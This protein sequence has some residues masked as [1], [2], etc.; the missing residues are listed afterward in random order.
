MR[1]EDAFP[2]L[3]RHML[4]EAIWWR[5]YKHWGQGYLAGEGLTELHGDRSGGLKIINGMRYTNAPCVVQARVYE[6][7]R[8]WLSAV[9]SYPNGI[10]A[11]DRYFWELYSADLLPDPE[12]F[13]TEEEMEQRVRELL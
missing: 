5:F 9:Y 3:N 11:E 10:G 12:H 7:E 6:S 1:E 8:G 13:D 4:T 2:G